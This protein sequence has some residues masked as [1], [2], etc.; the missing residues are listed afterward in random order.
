MPGREAEVIVLTGC[1]DAQRMR[2]A[3]AAMETVR[4][5]GIEQ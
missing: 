5:P 2:P 1:R 4:A 3:E